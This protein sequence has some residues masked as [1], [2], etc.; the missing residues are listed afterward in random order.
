MEIS[1]ETPLRL[2]QPQGPPAPDRHHQPQTHGQHPGNG[3]TEV[4]MVV[5]EVREVEVVKVVDCGCQVE[6]PN[7]R[8]AARLRNLIS[9]GLPG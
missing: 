6:E 4:V 1:T 9:D 3:F 7:L 8:W 5:D 2:L